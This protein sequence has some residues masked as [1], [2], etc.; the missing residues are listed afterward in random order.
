MNYRN[1]FLQWVK[2]FTQSSAS[3]N[4]SIVL[5]SELKPSRKEKQEATVFSFSK[6]QITIF[7]I[8]GA[9]IA[10]AAYLIFNSLSLLYLILTGLLISVALETFIKWGQRYM[11]RGLAIG[12]MYFF[13]VIFMLAGLIIM[14]PFL[15]KQLASIISLLITQVSTMGQKIS[16]MGLSAY[17][18]SMSW[19]PGII[20]SYMLDSLWSNAWQLQNTV[21][22]NIS[23]LVST[24]SM[25]AS[26][27]SSM[28]LS[29]VWSIF[30][31]L[32]Q[33][34][35]VLTIAVFFSIEKERVI[36]FFVHHTSST[37]TYTQFMSE[38][39]D[40]FYK[41]MGTWLK[42]QLALCLYIFV[43][44]YVALLVL[45]W[46][47]MPL[48]NAFSLALMAWFTEFIPYVW[49]ILGAVP[50]IIVATII[51]GWKG[52]LVVGIIYVVIQQIENNVLV[53]ML[54]NK[55]LGVSPLLILLCALFF[56]SI[57]GF[58]GVLMAVPFA[59]LITM[60]AKKDFE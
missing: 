53:P 31:I 52:F 43:V 10:Y 3:A 34:A 16:T 11:N 41:K 60:V 6:G 1:S 48:P 45:W 30:T 18:E 37:L 17:I 22:Q 12:I 54:M 14:L 21:M 29:L 59:I 27:I 44:V 50:A 9:L 38:K 15:L 4:N 42:T 8:I 26:N 49:P 13:L 39:V 33:I 2:Q 58:I 46:F 32:G 36:R 51:Y 19:I 56:G 23:A 20:K 28:A 7:W 40:I 35:L 25:Y 5:W 47:G 24:G 55:S 57:L